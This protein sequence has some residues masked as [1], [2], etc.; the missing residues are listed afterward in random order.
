MKRM[1]RVLAA[2]C[3]LLLAA[4]TPET[5]PAVPQSALPVVVYAAYEDK[6]YLPALLEEFTRD[7]GI[8]VIVRNG[9]LPGIIDDVLQD[10]VSPPAD[11]LLTPS[12]AG[13]WRAAEEGQLRP[14]YS[15]QLASVPAWLRDPD[16]YW[17]ALSYQIAVIAYD[18]Q[19]F[20]AADLAAY[21]S[22]A[23]PQ[24][25]Q[26]LCLSSSA[27]PINRSVIAMLLQKLGTREAEL[28]VRGWVA[29]LA[30]PPF[31]T[32][33]ELVGALESGTCAAAIVS[34]GIAATGRNVALRTPDQ[35]SAAAEAMGIT[36]HARNPEGAAQLV[37]W[38]LQHQ[39]Q[40]RHAATVAA[41]PAATDVEGI[42]LR[43]AAIVQAA[44]GDTEAGLLAERA[45]YR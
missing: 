33:Q 3:V 19:Q 1:R 26:K 36:R 10:R 12:V 8:L 9:T 11:V 27:L 32:E 5:P 41:S 6:T 39:V 28:A 40:A 35:T 20:A 16:N 45:R 43:T 38:L 17:V 24:F 7:T 13:V 34:A 25:R 42:G 29:N 21:E 4:C 31:D 22:L 14:N 37:D 30:A 18:P 23:L 44:S 15:A 2:C